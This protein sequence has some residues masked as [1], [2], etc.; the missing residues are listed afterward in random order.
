MSEYFVLFLIIVVVLAAVL[1]QDFVLT[2][3]YF[4]VGSY[5]VARWWSGRAL[6][7]V[8]VQ[9]EFNNR[10]FIND[11]ITIRLTL[12]NSTY[13]P[14]V[15][16]RLADSMP[17]EIVGAEV[18]RRVLT[19]GPHARRS[20]E[21]VLQPGRRGYYQIGPLFLYSGDVLGLAEERA[22]QGSIEHL[23]VYPRILPF[24]EIKLP[25]RSPMGTLR[26]HQPIFEDP[27]RIRGKRD[28]VAGDS[29]RRVD[30]KSTAITGR[31]QVKLFEPSIALET[32]IF[33]NLYDEDYYYRSRND[34]TELGIVTAASIAAWVI[35]KKQTIGLVT[36]GIDILS[37]DGSPAPKLPPEKGRSH[38]MRILDVLAR[39]QMTKSNSFVQLLQRERPR[40]AWG[41]T[42][43]LVTGNAD[44]AVFDEL[45]QMRRAGLNVVLI[46][47]GHVIEADD[48]KHRAQHFGIPVHQF[49]SEKDLDVWR[50]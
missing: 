30:W 35:G 16:L 26:H 19:L 21:Y 41:T 45:F 12:I 34:A 31:L 46:L 47:C 43:I 14:V 4:V 40:L 6:K 29:L 1:Q 32:A 17:V 18:F 44:H 28:Y 15:W 25:S 8:L 39:I 38:L 36:N 50:Q 24:T 49:T 2:L 20:Y 10:A 48:I 23:T 37:D 3:F 11:K 22:R 13:L 5:A 27:T 33:L 9:R 7:S 42:V